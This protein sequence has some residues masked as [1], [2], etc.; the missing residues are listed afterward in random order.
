ML[1]IL[2]YLSVYMKNVDLKNLKTPQEFIE[3][4]ENLNIS[5]VS[6]SEKYWFND[7]KKWEMVRNKL[8]VSDDD[9]NWSKDDNG[10]LV[11]FWYEDRNEG[12]IKR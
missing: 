11:S 3:S 2:L 9:V 7:R 4:S 6:D 5:D 12:W 10:K 1:L 8:D